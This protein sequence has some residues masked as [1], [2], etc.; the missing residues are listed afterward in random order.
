MCVFLFFFF[1][2]EV[3]KYAFTHT[4]CYVGLDHFWKYLL[5]P[6]ADVQSPPTVIFPAGSAVRYYFAEGSC[7]LYG[8]LALWRLICPPLR[9]RDQ[10]QH[11]ILSVKRVSIFQCPQELSGLPIKPLT[12][13]FLPKIWC[14]RTKRAPRPHQFQVILGTLRLRTLQFSSGSCESS[15]ARL[16]PG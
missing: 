1:L 11:P 6:P 16:V 14:I 15:H 5:K 4:R 7:S 2:E 12:F 9:W 10:A 3:R 13:L 8:P